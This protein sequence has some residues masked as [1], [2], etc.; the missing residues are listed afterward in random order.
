MCPGP[1]RT[2]LSYSM[3][4]W[5]DLRCIPATFPADVAVQEYSAAFLGMEN[6]AYCAWITNPAHWGGGIELAILAS[7]Y[8]REIAAWNLATGACHVFGED[9]GV[10]GVS[11]TLCVV[12][13]GVDVGVPH[14][15]VSGEQ[16]RVTGV[17]CAMRSS[18]GGSHWR[19]CLQAVDDQLPCIC[20]FHLRPSWLMS[21]CVALLPHT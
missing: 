20:L 11:H 8:R 3:A 17:R 4:C 14:A 15:G 6:A 12:W 2:V 9:S 5:T 21:S 19:E 18:G 13:C 10:W 7:H 1:C 16:P